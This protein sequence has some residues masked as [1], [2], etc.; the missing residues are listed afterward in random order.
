MQFD[1]T[2]IENFEMRTEQSKEKDFCVK[3]DK[4]EEITQQEGDVKVNILEKEVIG[5]TEDCSLEEQ[6]SMRVIR[7]DLP[8]GMVD[9]GLEIA[10]K[11]H[12]ILIRMVMDENKEQGRMIRRLE[13]KIVELENKMGESV[14]KKHQ[15]IN[16]TLKSTSSTNK[17]SNGMNQDDCREIVGVVDSLGNAVLDR[18]EGDEPFS[19]M[20]ELLDIFN[21]TKSVIT[22]GE[23]YTKSS[24][25]VCPPR[26]ISSR[27][28]LRTHALF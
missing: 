24:P 28:K 22:T 17:S 26:V 18:C 3:P 10:E 8:G 19:S 4:C 7:E 14:V 25:V 5:M 21:K 12:S 20:S 9:Q 13:E 11:D 1:E 2:K 27:V 16:R 15:D 23:S 6:I